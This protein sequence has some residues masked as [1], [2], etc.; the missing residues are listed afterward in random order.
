MF[1]TLT[2][3]LVQSRESVPGR[4]PRGLTLTLTLTLALTLTLTLTLTLG[5]ACLEEVLGAKLKLEHRTV[6]LVDHQHRAHALAK[7]RGRGRR[8]QAEGEEGKV[9]KGRG[10]REYRGIEEGGG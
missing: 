5:K 3:E 7:G 4:G 6:D 9:R 2:K 10:E 8:V 1:T